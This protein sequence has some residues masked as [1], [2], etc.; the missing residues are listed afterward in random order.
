MR[1]D[2]LLPLAVS[3]P[4]RV[5]DLPEPLREREKCTLRK[6]AAEI[7]IEGGFPG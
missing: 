4:G 2:K 7:V 3:R 6:P 5:A 1:H